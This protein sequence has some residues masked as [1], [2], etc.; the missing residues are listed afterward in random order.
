MAAEKR[1]LR[2]ST[3]DPAALTVRDIK[4]CRHYAEHGNATQAYQFAGF[5]AKSAAEMAYRLLKKVQIR[6]YIREIQRRA[7]DAA[8]VS[9]ELVVQ[10]GKRSGFADRRKLYDENGVLLPV[11]MWPDD[12]AACVVEVETVEQKDADGNV[13]AYVRKVKTERRTEP[14]KLLAQ[15]LGMLGDDQQ[16]AD[17]KRV[18]VVL[19]PKKPL[20]DATDG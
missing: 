13:F 16:A 2:H 9:A 15:W 5:P 7:A 12:V 1:R 19:P 3:R 6:R 11:H 18:L 10:G 4:F 17:D 20:P 8:D 14:Q